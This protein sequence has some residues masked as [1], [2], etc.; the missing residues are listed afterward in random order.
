MEVL[1]AYVRNKSPLPKGWLETP[2]EKRKSLPAVTTDVQSA[3]TVIGRREAKNDLMFKRLV[4]G[5]SNLSSAQLGNAD[6]DGADLDG[7]ILNDA[8][9]NFANLT[10]ARL[11]GANLTDAILTGAILNYFADLYFANLT[12]VKLKGADL[13][14]ANLTG[15]KG[16]TPEQIKQARDWQKAHYDDGFRKQLGLPPEKS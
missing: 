16:I 1:T 4:L 8:E 14:D 3:L 9:L 2:V 7:A 12:G 10:R 15:A 5:Q 6:L 13:T 11:I